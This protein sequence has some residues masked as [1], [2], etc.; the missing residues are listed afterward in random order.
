[1][2]DI[3]SISPEIRREALDV[4]GAILKSIEESEILLSNI[5]LKA[6]RLA[7]L[8]N[9]SDFINIFEY[10]VSGYPST[11]DGIKTDVWKLAVIAGR[12]FRDG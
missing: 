12:I 2:L 11:K 3:A 4:S 5:A 6:I 9:D 1:M 7:R 8:L 10:E